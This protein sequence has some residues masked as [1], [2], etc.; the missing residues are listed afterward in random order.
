MSSLAKAND[1]AVA[2]AGHRKAFWGR[3]RDADGRSPL[4]LKSAKKIAVPQFIAGPMARSSGATLAARLFGMGSSFIFAVASARLLG[5]SGYGIV[6]VAISVMTVVA[7]LSLLGIDGLAVRQTASLQTSRA[8]TEL[9]RFVHWA[10]MTVVGASLTAAVLVALLSPLAGDYSRALLFA[11]VIV[12]LMAGMLLLKS[13]MQG[14]GNVAMSQ[15]PSEVVRWLVTLALIGALFIY[16]VRTSEAVIAAVVAALLFALLVSIAL[17][18]R[19]M[20][21]CPIG[22]GPS[23]QQRSWLKEAFPFL[24]IALFGIIGTELSTLLLGWLA[25]PREAGLFQPIAKAAP[26]M[27]LA[28]YSIEAA[29]APRIVGMWH[30]QDSAGLQRLMRRSAIAATIA[31]IAITGSILLAAP[32]IFLAFG[33]EFTVNVDYLY[34]VG[35]AQMINAAF[36]SAPLLLAM[37]GD[38]ATRLKAQAVTLIVQATLAIALIPSLGAAGAVISLT[39]AILTWSALHWWLALRKTGINTSAFSLRPS[40]RGETA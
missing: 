34:W 23:S 19:Q 29:L 8:W 33:R 17:F 12:P 40:P 35:A 27:L 9:R 7:T 22:D 21:S 14:L 20:S 39:V 10:C 4:A 24:A 38:M 5:P 31:T 1:K 26:V 6:A 25:G 18:R 13:M 2:V 15:M 36:G 32:L 30:Q 28:T 16:G 11:A 3:N 37:V